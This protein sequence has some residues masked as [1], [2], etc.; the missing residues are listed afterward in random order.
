VARGLYHR[1]A[2]KQLNALEVLVEESEWC[3]FD[4]KTWHAGARFW[5]NCRKN[6]MPTG[7]GLDK[8]V[9]IAAQVREQNAILVTN[10]TKHFER[11]GITFENWQTQTS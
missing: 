2:R 3:E 1:D 6:G 8:D 10:N 4:S 9:L 11:F 5:A 7:H